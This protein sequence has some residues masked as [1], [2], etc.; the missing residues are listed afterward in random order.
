MRKRP[1]AHSHKEPVS[2]RNDSPKP[3]TQPS[4]VGECGVELDE[5]NPGHV[6]LS[7]SEGIG[8]YT[9]VAT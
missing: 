5:E 2:P 7:F 4:M 6:S 3:A 9:S 8:T 1:K